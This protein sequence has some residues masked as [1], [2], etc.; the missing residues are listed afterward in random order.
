MIYDYCILGGGIIGLATAHKLSEMQ[1]GVSIHLIEKETTLASHQ[2]GH[3]SGVIHAGIYYEQGSLKA[4][5][6]R[7]GL[8]A[9]VAFC[10][11]HNLAYKQ[12]GKLIVATNAV[13]EAR[14]D[15][16]HVRANANGL[17]LPRISGE[18]LHELEPNIAGIAALL[19]AETGIVD[20]KEISAKLA[21]LIVAK[22]ADITLG[23]K[24]ERIVEKADFV[25]IGTKSS[26]W[27]AKKLIVCGGLQADRLARL[28]GL[29]I[30]FRIIPFRGE[31]FK[32]PE[33]KNSIIQH[34][35]YPAPDPALP[36]LGV[37]LTKMIDG[38]VTVGPNAVLGLAREG[39]PKLSMNLKDIASFVSY[40]GFWKLMW[41]HRSHTMHE[42]KG[43]LSRAVYLEDCQKYCPEL[44]IADLLP[45]RA[46]IRAQV[47]T[48]SGQAMHDFMYAQTD[49][50]LHIY[51]APS[52]AATSALPIGEM[53][54]Q[55]CNDNKL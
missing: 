6:C 46:G 55:K 28:A 32:L 21:E 3:N 51:N 22:G 41:E 25:E 43:S 26:T 13:E 14:L 16:L 38:S 42:L 24:V 12:C 7:E 29:S 10:K 47:V 48:K 39:Y 23:S 33:D 4:K 8:E 44:A 19:S 11:L 20:Y 17:K 53:I 2:T 15:V 49:R 45:C 54:A 34:L 40:A 9:T 1:P 27:K 31:Y 50:M 52:P 36:F 30:D 5:L 18:E 37:H 35:I